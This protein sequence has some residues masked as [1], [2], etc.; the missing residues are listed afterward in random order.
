MPSAKRDS[1]IFFLYSLYVNVEQFEKKTKGM[2]IATT[3]CALIN[4]YL[5]II[6]IPKYGY[7]A[8]A[9]TTMAG[10]LLMLL[11]HYVVLKHHRFDN[12]YNNR[13]IFSV[14]FSGLVLS[15]LMPI[16]YSYN[17]FRYIVLALYIVIMLVLIYRFKD[18]IFK[19]IKA[20]GQDV[21]V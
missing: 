6:F 7:I 15:V 11:F 9:Y 8:A 18:R 21:T 2:A 20:D 12:L 14:A 13:L 4:V 16:I 17:V 3:G 19:L 1:F 10:Y 5:N